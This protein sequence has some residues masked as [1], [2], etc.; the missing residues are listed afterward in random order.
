VPRV[1][2]AESWPARLRVLFE[3]S[4]INGDMAEPAI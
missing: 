1:W 3:D 4:N 2:F